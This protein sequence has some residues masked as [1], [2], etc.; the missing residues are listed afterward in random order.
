MRGG[1]RSSVARSPLVIGDVEN[2]P[3]EFVWVASPTRWQF[4]R[5][6]GDFGML[7]IRTASNDPRIVVGVR[8]KLRTMPSLY[9]TSVEAYD[10]GRQADIVSRAFLAKVFVSMGFVAL[11]LAALG[12][13]GVLAY[14]V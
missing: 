9:S 4:N 1:C 7:L 12:L 3:G 6:G 10:A 5:F 8:R 2:A 14:A 11:A 13:Y